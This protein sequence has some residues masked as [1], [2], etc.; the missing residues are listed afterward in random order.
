MLGRNEKWVNINCENY[1][2]D[3][4][5]NKVDFFKN[6]FI[7]FYEVLKMLEKRYCVAQAY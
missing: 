3:K 6:L 1:K 2:R 5:G 4:A 7:F